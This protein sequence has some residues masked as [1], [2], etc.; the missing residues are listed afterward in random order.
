MDGGTG[1][2]DVRTVYIDEVFALNAL[3]DYLLL[4]CAAKLAG[5]PFRRLRFALA[6]ALGGLYA[7]GAALP[8]WG[9][10]THPLCKLASAV[11][12]AL[13]AYGASH[14]LLRLTLV[15]FGVAAAFGGSTLALQMLW[16][17]PRA[18]DLQT[19]LLCS[20]FCYVFLSLVFRR[21]A[22]HGGGE[23]AGAE[24]ELGGRR[25][26]LTALVDTGNTLTDPVTG[27]PVMVA[28]GERL[29][30][31]FPPGEGP[32]PGELNDPVSALERRRGGRWR[33]L[34]YRAVGV[35]HAL[36]LAVRVDNA[37][38]AGE[39]YGPILVALSPTPV[40]DGG[41]YSA[42]IGA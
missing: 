7:A 37:R 6:A 39:D 40:S 27:R 23:L 10:L 30:G 36:L 17:S 13:A 2:T 31:L 38:V 16:G 34:P 20:A 32:G 12:M 25:C 4:L 21:T 15:F 18:L 14:R 24:L 42:L 22:R 29:D 35:E 41:S 28:E 5:E 9:F 1:G 8:G 19:V 26:R 3:V 33:L 11:G